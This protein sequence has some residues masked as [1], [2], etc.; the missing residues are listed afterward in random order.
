M[1][2]EAIGVLL[3]VVLFLISGLLMECMG[4]I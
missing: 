4:G 2:K 3:A 1:S